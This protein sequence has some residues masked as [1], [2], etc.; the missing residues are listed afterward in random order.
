MYSPE[1]I[2][3]DDEPLV[4]DDPWIDEQRE[5][6]ALE[7]LAVLY[8]EREDIDDLDDHDTDTGSPCPCCFESSGYHA[9]NVPDTWSEPGWAEPD[10]TRPCEYCCGTGTVESKLIIIDDTEFRN[11]DFIEDGYLSL[12]DTQGRETLYIEDGILEAVL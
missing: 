2:G 9:R 8:D 3:D 10:P 4:D 7:A 12:V 6:E 1:M 5:L 11:D